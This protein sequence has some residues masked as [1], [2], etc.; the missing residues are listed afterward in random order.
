MSRASSVK[1][2]YQDYLRL[3]DD[4]RYEIIDGELFLTPAPGTYHQRISAHLQYLLTRRVRE[5]GEGEIF[6]APCD[7]LLSETD[8][9]QSD[10]F[11][12]ARGR[13]RI[14]EEKYVSAAPDLVIEILSESTVKRDRGIKSK[15]YE[16]SGVKELWLVDPWEKTVEIFRRDESGF[17]RHA[18]FDSSE[19]IRTP[20]FPGLEISLLEVF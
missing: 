6:N 8:V 4:Q 2:T 3:P 15:L 11:F 20:M 1:F 14:V 9:V 18:R 7:L 19:T 12:I 5:M 10:L 13:E 17:V 16:R